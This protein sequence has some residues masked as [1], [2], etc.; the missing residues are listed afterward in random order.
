[1]L[2]DFKGLRRAASSDLDRAR[3]WFE[4]KPARRP[5]WSTRVASGT[6]ALAEPGS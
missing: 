3:A 5:R 4:E 6:N 2:T 1:M